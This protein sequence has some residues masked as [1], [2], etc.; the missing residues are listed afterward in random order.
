MDQFTKSHKRPPTT[1]PL[2]N[3][4]NDPKQQS[5]CEPLQIPHLT[6][7]LANIEVQTIVYLSIFRWNGDERNTGLGWDLIEVVKELI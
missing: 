3:I 6:W 7:L 4:L 5:N 2:P 1:T